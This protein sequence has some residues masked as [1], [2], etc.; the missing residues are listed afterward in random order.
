MVLANIPQSVIMSL[1]AE[2]EKFSLDEKDTVQ[3]GCAPTIDSQIWSN[4][5]KLK[6]DQKVI[7]LIFGKVFIK[8]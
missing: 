1:L 4:D 5:T 3:L 8:N 7:E 6:E 2:A